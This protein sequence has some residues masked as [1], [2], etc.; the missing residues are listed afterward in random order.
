MPGGRLDFPVLVGQDAG[1][2]EIWFDRLR[3]VVCFPQFAF[4]ALFA[5]YSLFQTLLEFYFEFQPQC[6]LEVLKRL[7]IFGTLGHVTMKL[8]HMWCINGSRSLPFWSLHI[9]SGLSLRPVGTF[10]FKHYYLNNALVGAFWISLWLSLFFP[11]VL[12]PCVLL[13]AFLS[14]VDLWRFCNFH[15]WLFCLAGFL[16]PNPVVTLQLWLG[17]LYFWSG[18]HKLFGKEFYSSLGPVV[19][20]P[21]FKLLKPLITKFSP[22]HEAQIILA[23]TGLGV[24]TETLMGFLLLLP[25]VTPLWILKL[26]LLYNL[27]LHSYIIIFIGYK[28]SILAFWCWNAMCASVCQ[29][30]FSTVFCL[31]HVDPQW[32][33][34]NYITFFMMVA[35][36]TTVLFGKSPDGILSH[37]YFAPGWYPR[38]YLLL[39]ASAAASIPTIVNRI[40]FETYSSDKEPRMFTRV[41]STLEKVI[42]KNGLSQD[43]IL[44]TLNLQ[45]H[46]GVGMRGILWDHAIAIDGGWV[47]MTFNLGPEDPWKTFYNAGCSNFWISVLKERIKTNGIHVMIN[48]FNVFQGH[49]HDIELLDHNS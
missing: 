11:S 8:G 20:D 6:N 28:H 45:H 44:E 40:G 22:A 5:F 15:Q 30:V 49:H 35:F 33:S 12:L 37:A 1:P 17:G 25:T 43:K 16:F 18:F 41:L 10:L 13:F 42:A 31:N 27:F 24:G 26:V 38:S 9:A 32:S 23:V 21:I 36:P 47:D 34:W 3:T 19:F 48:K 39:P 2:W 4:C 7:V 29:Y 46:Q 14:L